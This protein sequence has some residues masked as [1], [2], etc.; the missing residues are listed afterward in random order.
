MKSSL[1][2]RIPTPPKFLGTEGRRLW[3][4]ILGQFVL[5]DAALPILGAACSACDRWHAARIVVEAEGMYKPDRFGQ[6]KLHPAAL[7]ERDSRKA[8]VDQPR[9]NTA[10]VR[11]LC[12]E[13]NWRPSGSISKVASG[14]K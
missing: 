7:I 4:S 5:D 8:M 2:P 3:R 6:P 10:D 11:C 1:H 13:A 14:V 9:R 12:T